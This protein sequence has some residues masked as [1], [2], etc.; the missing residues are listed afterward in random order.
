[1][2]ACVIIALTACSTTSSLPEDEKLYL[3]IEKISYTDYE[4]NAH[5]VATQEELEAALACPPNASLFGSSTYRSPFPIGLYIWNAFSESDNKFGSWIGKTF[6][7]KPVLM[8]VVNP[9]LRASVAESTLKAYGYFH[10][11]VDAEEIQTKNSKKQKVAYHVKPGHLFTL[12]SIEYRN[13]PEEAM[14]LID[15]TKKERMIKKDDP[16]DVSVLDGERNRIVNLLRD[17]G[18]YYF[19]PSYASYLADTLQVPGKVQVRLQMADSIPDNALRKWY[20]GKRDVNLRRNY[21]EVLDS[22]SER[23][24]FTIHYNG[25]KTPVRP[26]VFMRDVKLQKGKPYSYTDYLESINK[27]SA[28]TIFNRV[29]FVFT[30]RDTTATCDTLDMEIN[31]VMDKLYYTYIESNLRGKTTGYLGPQLILG[32][33]KKNAFKGGEVVD[34]NVHGSY[35]WKL[36]KTHDDSEVNSN[37]YEYGLDVSVELPRLLL[38]FKLKR[39]RWYAPPSTLF[40]VSTNHINRSGFFKRNIVSGEI[41]YQFHP[42]AN[43]QHKFSPLSVE[44]NYLKK[45]TEQFYEMI[46]QSPYLLATIAAD[47]FIPKMK[48]TLSWLS[49][50]NYRNPFYLETSVSEAGNI[51]SLGYMATGDK[52]NDVGKQLFKNTY[53][54]FLKFETNLTKIWTVD[55][56]MQLVGHV[57]GGI[58]FSYGNSNYAPYTEQFYVGGA[59]SIR[60]FAA[61]SIGP[62][63][64]RSEDKRWRYLEQ[65]GDVKFQANL[66]WRMRVWGNLF[67]AIFLDAGNVWVRANNEFDDDTHF[68]F[69]NALDQMAVGTGVGLRYDLG[70]FVV[71]LDWGFGLHV[72]YETSR[73]GWFNIPSFRDGNAIH[74]AIGYP[75]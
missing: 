1:M 11:T 2:A 42:K 74:F 53:A 40:K 25:K 63:A 67:G 13:F 48:Y 50:K 69:S 27:L 65:T 61:R 26:G 45:G 4:K 29:D 24:T 28:N 62:G 39:R 7:S 68:T 73:S 31:C 35:D 59:N 38:P 52:W 8:S 41:T 23:R 5:F 49:P 60:A 66:E 56:G 16:F 57:N 71:R 37:S 17:N 51:L 21:R 9:E 34:V 64:Y 47:V 36:S 30:P 72:P 20:I 33:S 18:Y 43:W 32:V 10:G 12:D 19:H 70:Y 3:G 58:I 6:G 54:Q 75:F 55:D 44:Y 15:S 46:G 14:A 22:A